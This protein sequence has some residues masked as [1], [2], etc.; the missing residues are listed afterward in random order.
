MLFSE[1]IT[2]KGFKVKFYGTRVTKSLGHEK[3]LSVEI[4]RGSGGEAILFA[5]NR[6][7]MRDS[8]QLLGYFIDLISGHIKPTVASK[9]FNCYLLLSQ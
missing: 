8:K 1:T 3:T 2:S 7:V 4:S 6:R 5:L 9:T